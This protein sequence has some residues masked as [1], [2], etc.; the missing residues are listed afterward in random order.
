V[1]TERTFITVSMA[2]LLLAMA[3]VGGYLVSVTR[4]QVSY[5]SAIGPLL[6][7]YSHPWQRAMFRPIEHLDRS[8][9]PGRWRYDLL[10]QTSSTTR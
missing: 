6:A 10:K 7:A 1:K 8:L 5:G 9:F 3:Y 2:L 4:L